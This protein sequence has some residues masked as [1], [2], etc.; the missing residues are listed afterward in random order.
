MVYEWD[1]VTQGVFCCTILFLLLQCQHDNFSEK[2][3]SHKI[4]HKSDFLC[5]SLFHIGNLQGCKGVTL[6]K[7]DS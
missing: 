2:E 4:S 7:Y 3:V 1:N 6:V 5:H